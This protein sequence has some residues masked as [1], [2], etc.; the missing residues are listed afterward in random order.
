MA[1]DLLKQ[2]LA[3]IQTIHGNAVRVNSAS[4][5]RAQFIAEIV[6]RSIET[7]AHVEQIAE[8]SQQNTEVLRDAAANTS[9]IVSG[10]QE[11]VDGLMEGRNATNA[12]AESLKNFRTRFD[13]VGRISV[14]ITGIAKQTNLLA[15]NAMIEASHGGEAGRGFAVVANEVKDLAEGVRKSAAAIQEQIKALADQLNAL[16]DQCGTLEMNMEASATAG[17]ENQDRIVHVA[18]YITEAAASADSTADSAAEQV[19]RF[20]AL[21]G[22]LQKVKDDTEKA[23]QGSATNMGLAQEVWDALDKL[24]SPEKA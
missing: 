24:C 11:V 4:K 21:V 13:D 6:E 3:T 8:S 15:M 10:V 7:G 9:K 14:E 17:S 18:H 2:A 16:A 22:Q 23:I 1:D 12:M 5:D 19:K 20:T